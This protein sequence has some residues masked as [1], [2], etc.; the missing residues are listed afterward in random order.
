MER[1]PTFR[2]SRPVFGS[3]VLDNFGVRGERM[4]VVSGG[5]GRFGIPENKRTTY[6]T[7]LTKRGFSPEVP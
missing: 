5:S 1:S 2:V 7:H 4:T 6:S 3:S